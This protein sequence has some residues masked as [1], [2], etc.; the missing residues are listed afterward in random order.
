MKRVTHLMVF[1]VLA[2]TGSVHA[3]WVGPDFFC[4]SNYELVKKADAI[5]VAKAV[6]S[7][8][9]LDRITFEVV[10][11]LKGAVGEDRVSVYGRVDNFRGRSERGDFS[12]ARP[13][14]YAGMGTALD[15]R[16]GQHY[17]LF[18]T[19]V[20][21]KWEAG[22]PALSRTQEEIDPEDSPWLKVVRLYLEIAAIGDYEK[23]KAALRALHARAVAPATH[24]QYPP[25]LVEDIDRHFQTVS[26][27]KS[28]T[29]LIGM[30]NNASSDKARVR[31]LYA[32]AKAAY[33]EALPLI[34]QH[35]LDEGWAGGTFLDYLV[36]VKDR[37]SVPVIAVY[38]LGTDPEVR[39]HYAESLVALADDAQMGNML[40][41]LEVSRDPDNVEIL[42]EWFKKHP[43]ARAVRI[44]SEL[45]GG[46]Y[47]DG[48][49]WHLTLGLA[50]L[51]DEGVVRWAAEKVEAIREG[52]PGKA[53][54]ILAF[55]PTKAAEAA[56]ADLMARADEKTLNRIFYS[57]ITDGN[58]N[59]KRWDHLAALI[60]RPGK[61]EWLVRNIQ[62]ALRGR[63]DERARM[64]LKDLD[65]HSPDRAS[66]AALDDSP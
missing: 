42:L 33:P 55:S 4:P 53:I 65:D 23:E 1:L 21:D 22:E 34:R 28:Y 15:Y 66:G 64:L 57:L 41:V 16:I 46:K 47:E 45:V 27:M 19:R 7:T 5:V 52:D 3:F 37:D 56:L 51:G 12:R 25:G 54:A 49:K 18:L 6:E 30:Y 62:S 8:E 38:Y 48:K 11:S 9:S 2:T 24:T 35:T 10:E 39:R 14:T 36:A 58:E 26:P 13:G 60:R 63:S 40:R 17:L 43:D 31:I 61:S 20:G 32:F 50:S 44:L 29:D 59:P